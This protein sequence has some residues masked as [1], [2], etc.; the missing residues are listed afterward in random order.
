MTD[1]DE[2]PLDDGHLLGV[3]ELPGHRGQRLATLGTA[4]AI[5]LAELVDLI[6]DGQSG[7]HARPVPGMRRP[8][9]GGWLRHGR[10]PLLARR[11]EQRVV[12]LS[13]EFLQ[14]GEL[15]LEH[16]AVLAA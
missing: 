9:R 3:L 12:A 11:T 7:L 5:G 8:R 10:R 4:L 16:C 15:A 13:E 6:D 14:K 2:P 1:D